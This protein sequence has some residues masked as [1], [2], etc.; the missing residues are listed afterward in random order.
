M[1]IETERI[2]KLNS[3]GDR[4]DAEYVLYWAQMNRRVDA[5][6]GL[7]FAVELANRYRLPVLYYEGLT[8][9]YKNANDRLHTFILEAVPET[10]KR[11]KRAGI[12]YVFY[13]RKTKESRNDVLYELAPKRQQS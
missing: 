4:P 10:A 6:H 3:A 1:A 5:N 9:T 8:C 2:S 7:L 11:L 12:G 13:L